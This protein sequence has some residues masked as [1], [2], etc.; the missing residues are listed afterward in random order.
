MSPKVYIVGAGPGRADLLTLRAARILSQADVVFYDRLVSTEVL[1][2]VNSSADRVYIGKEE[3]E[4]E[5]TQARILDLL[6]TAAVSNDVIV[7]L[8]GGDPF[9][10]GRGGEEWAHL[11]ERGIPVEIVPG[12]SSS[13]SVPA[14]AGIPATFRGVSSGFAVVTGHLRDGFRETWQAYAKVE[15]LV[16]L[17]GVRNR[18]SIAQALID[19]GRPAREPACFIE[20]GTT[21]RERITVTTLGAIAKGRTSVESPA[22]LVIGEVVRLRDLLAGGG[23]AD[24]PDTGKPDY[25][26][27]ETHARPN[28]E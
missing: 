14:L 28:H 23:R 10:F 9:V 18:E 17:M 3:G 8:K 21:A 22:V 2:L 24:Q 1:E 25:G 26:A 27:E 15:T 11:A 20:N 16:V 12:V 19:A 13:L 5:A 4:Q 6:E 7:R